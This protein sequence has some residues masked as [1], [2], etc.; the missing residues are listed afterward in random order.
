MFRERMAK[1]NGQT[2]A[3]EGLRLD[4][5]GGVS[6]GLPLRGAPPVSME[7]TGRSTADDR[8]D[9]DS[10]SDVD[11]DVGAEAEDVALVEAQ[12]AELAGKAGLAA[13]REA[14]AEVMDCGTELEQMLKGRANQVACN[15]C[16]AKAL[17]QAGLKSEP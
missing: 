4:I 5:K 2:E 8:G 15:V 12:T 13:Q 9:S 16:S 11:E 1:R 10:D 17:L 6:G 3:G 14:W 7:R